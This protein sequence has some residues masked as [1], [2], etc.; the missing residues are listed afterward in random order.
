MKRVLVVEDEA[1]IRFLIV[2]LLRQLDF[3]VIEA[4][5]GEDALDL[6]AQQ[7]P[8]DVV[9][10]DLQL[11]RVDGLQLIEIVKREFP[12]VKVVVV[13]AYQDRLAEALEKGVHN[14]LRKPFSRQQFIDLLRTTT[15]LQQED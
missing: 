15:D 6:L 7:P 11:P 3:D 1:N 4:M 8:F 5:N 2:T 12:H 9:V 10:T 14:Q 13:S